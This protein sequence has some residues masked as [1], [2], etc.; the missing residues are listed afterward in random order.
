MQAAVLEM[1]S[2]TSSSPTTW[3]KT[4]GSAKERQETSNIVTLT[5]ALSTMKVCSFSVTK[6]TPRRGLSRTL[7][8]SNGWW[9][10]S[11]AGAAA[12]PSFLRPEPSSMMPPKKKDVPNTSSMFESTDPS[13]VA[14]T[15]STRPKRNVW[16]VMIISTALPKVAFKRPLITSLWRQASSSSVASPNIFA[17]GISARKFS[18]KVACGPQPSRYERMPKG[19]ATNAKLNGWYKMDLMLSR[20]RVIAD[21]GAAGSRSSISPTAP[22]SLPALI[23]ALALRMSR[24]ACQ[25]TYAGTSGADA[26]RSMPSCEDSRKPLTPPREEDMAHPCGPA[27]CLELSPPPPE[28]P[29]I[30]AKAGSGFCRLLTTGHRLLSEGRGGV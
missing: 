27:P 8:C 18:Q 1:L 20:F 13:N 5:K 21:L 2:T 4:V 11:N 19:K 26:L 9:T 12:L 15:T 10:P 7:T 14:L 30:T 16:T 6:R 28:F 24:F 17:S 23:P 25:T 22:S 3:E 29:C